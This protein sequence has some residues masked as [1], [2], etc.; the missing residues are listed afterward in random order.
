MC[1]NKPHIQKI[2]EKNFKQSI[3]Q[4]TESSSQRS[5]QRY[6]WFEKNPKNLEVQLLNNL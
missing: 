4:N 6:P 2:P 3:K 5:P 1:T